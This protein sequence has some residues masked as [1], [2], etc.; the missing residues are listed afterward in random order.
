MFVLKE[1][2]LNF[3]RNRNKIIFKNFLKKNNVQTINLGRNKL[4]L[5]DLKKF[6][7]STTNL[8]KKNIHAWSGKKI[9]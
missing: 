3:K 8:F 1:K 2:H 7:R 9:Y 6:Y 4:Y 5:Y